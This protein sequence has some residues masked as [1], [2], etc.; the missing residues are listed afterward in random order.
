MTL[1]VFRQEL[2]PLRGRRE[3]SGA[4]EWSGGGRGFY[5]KIVQSQVA[6]HEGDN[7]SCDGTG[8]QQYTI[9]LG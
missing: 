1:P 8:H 4:A 6:G 2:L 5:G 9:R 3:E 7:T